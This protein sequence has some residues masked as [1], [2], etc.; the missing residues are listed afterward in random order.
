MSPW[1]CEAIQAPLFSGNKPSKSHTIYKYPR[2]VNTEP[3]TMQIFWKILAVKI[4]GWTVEVFVLF[5]IFY[6][7]FKLYLKKSLCSCAR[8]RG[9]PAWHINLSPTC[10]YMISSSRLKKHNCGSFAP[11]GQVLRSWHM[12]YSGGFDRYSYRCCCPSLKA[13]PW[14][15]SVH[16]K[17]FILLHT[18]KFGVSNRLLDS[19]TKIHY[20]CTVRANLAFLC[21]SVKSPSFTLLTN[22]FM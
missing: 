22:T 5:I 20:D 19:F 16:C 17:F 10:L 21:A 3:V 15:T 18:L 2:L 11:Q 14:A 12:I 9:N 7:N 8:R 1:P 6:V 13:K 4:N